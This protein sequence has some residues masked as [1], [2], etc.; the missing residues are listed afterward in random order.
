MALRLGVGL[1]H[2]RDLLGAVDVAV[3]AEEL[4]YEN[5]WIP[6][7]YG[8]DA[9]TVL[10][11]IAARTS[12]ISLGTGIL[13]MVART[14]TNTAM[15]AM[16]LDEL[17]GGRTILGLGVSG[18][19]VVEGWHGESFDKPLARTREYIEIIRTVVRREE[20]LAFAGKVYNIP[21]NPE[22]AFPALKSSMRPTRPAIPIYLAANG[23]KNLALTAEIADGWLPSLYCPEQHHLVEEQL[24]VGLDKRDPELGPLSIATNVQAFVG[25]YIDACRDL[26]RPYL[27]LYIGGMGS[28]ESNFYKDVVTR[29]GYGEAADVVQDLYLSGRQKDAAAAVPDE[30]V[31]LL[32]LV[33][34]RDVVRERL[35]VWDESGVD[36]LMIKTSDVRTLEAIRQLADEL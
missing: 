21:R 20:P 8:S 9:V 18:P 13:Q 12:S 7:A 33:G 34:P 29:F 32:A 1:H 24:A 15:T 17:S 25:D 28:R 3:A 6:E 35:R 10:A 36:R 16:T 26:A 2:S 11:Y 22:R 4:G 19:Q 5:A 31:D 14:P 23:P 27:A 30:L